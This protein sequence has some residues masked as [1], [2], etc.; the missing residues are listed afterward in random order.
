ME[1]KIVAIIV[2]LILSVV[3]LSGCTGQQVPTPTATPTKTQTPTPT[4]PSD[5]IVFTSLAKL[6]DAT[7]ATSYSYSFCQPDSARSGALCGGLAGA[8]T[9][10]TGGNPPYSFSHQLG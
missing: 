6:T 3:I 7:V 9:N 10:P 1:R 5:K 2:L 4:P 8:T